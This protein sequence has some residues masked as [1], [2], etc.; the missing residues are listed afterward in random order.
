MIRLVW[1]VW[2]HYQLIYG[3]S[4]MVCL[5]ALSVDIWFVSYGLSGGITS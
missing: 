5:V 4:R 1:S 2:W 3:L